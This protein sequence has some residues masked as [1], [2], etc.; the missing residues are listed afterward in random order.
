MKLNEML[1]SPA[2]LMVG[3]TQIMDGQLAMCICPDASYGGGSGPLWAIEN[4]R[5]QFTTKW[6][7]FYVEGIC[8]KVDPKNLKVTIDITLGKTWG[9]LEAGRTVMLHARDI[10][11][12]HAP[13]P[14]IT[15]QIDDTHNLYEVKAQEKRFTEISI[16]ELPHEVSESYEA[17]LNKMFG[18]VDYK[19]VEDLLKA[20][21]K[22]TCEINSRQETFMHEK[23]HPLMNARDQFRRKLKAFIQANS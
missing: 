15:Y 18:C 7:G 3:E 14:S 16:N 12:F 11:R 23:S 9:P 22:L 10:R 5:C 20:Y 1:Q 13:N 8:R 21:Q 4:H 17:A 19:K 2:E 6:Q